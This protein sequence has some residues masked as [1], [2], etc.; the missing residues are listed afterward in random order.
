M[1][2]NIQYCSRNTFLNINPVKFVYQQTVDIL[3]FPVPGIIRF[4][5]FR[6][7]LRILNPKMIDKLHLNR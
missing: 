3:R 6:I 4:D 7:L 5:D 1:Q 2:S